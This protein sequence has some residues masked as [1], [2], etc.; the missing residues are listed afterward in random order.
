VDALRRPTDTSA[1]AEPDGTHRPGP[2]PAPDGTHRPGPGPDGT[3]DLG[4][5]P[6]PAPGRTHRSGPGPDGTRD[7]GPDAWDGIRAVS[8]DVGGVLV[9]PNHDWL[10]DAL[11]A[12]G[13]EH[14]RDRFVEG[15][16]RAMAEV[17]RCLST[18][19]E[20]TDYRRGFLLA[21]GTPEGQLDLG[22][23]AMATSLT[24]AAWHQPIP[25]ARDAA[26]RLAGAGLRLAVT[27]NADGTV[28]DLLR[29]HGLAQVGE[30]PGIAVELVTDSGVLGVAKPDPAMFLATAEGLGLPPES[31]LH[32]GDGGYYDAEGARA[33]GMAGVHVDPFRLCP[34]DRHA[35]VESLAGLAADLAPDGRHAAPACD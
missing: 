12:A 19:E 15:H 10:A 2:G 26:D 17:D 20:F 33:V 34:D 21:V 31:V 14:D 5:G 28:E 23:A 25:G 6:G 3:R 11:T 16:Y 9:L 30:G 1:T 8:L 22:A 27:S 24:S 13:V 35:H 29:R 18:P 4:P 32:V 7:F